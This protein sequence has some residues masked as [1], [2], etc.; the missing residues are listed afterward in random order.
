MRTVSAQW[1]LTLR[2]SHQRITSVDAYYDGVRQGEIPIVDGSITYD[3]FAPAARRCTLVVPLER[4]GVN[5]NPGNNITAPLAANG[6]RLY[7]ECGV[8]HADRKIEMVSQG[9]Y[10]I[11]DWS[12]DSDEGTV[13]VTGSDLWSLLERAPIMANQTSMRVPNLVANRINDC[14]RQLLYPRLFPD[15]QPGWLPVEGQI[16]EYTMD[17]AP[18][19]IIGPSGAF[20]L[21]EGD[22]R[23][24]AILDLATAWPCQ[25]RVLDDGILHV[26]DPPAVPTS[27]TPVDL[28][29]TDANG[30]NP[31]VV[32]RAFKADRDK[33]YNSIVLTSRN[34]T[35]GALIGTSALQ[36][37]TGPF[38]AQGPFGYHPLVQEVRL[39]TSQADLSAM[40]HARLDRSIVYA[41][42]ETVAIV[43]DPAIELDDVVLIES[44]TIDAFKGRV[45]GIS[46]PLVSSGPMVLTVSNSDAATAAASVR[47]LEAV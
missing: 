9:W 18:G 32:Q 6:Q 40:A 13:T 19:R 36:Y 47:A 33:I 39:A 23:T 34:A 45:V 25:L 2:Q 26:Q 29:L 35:T 16:L 43:P 24:S 37:V 5:Y 44:A 1:P 30:A 20:Q 3:A 17:T 28:E 38:R 46:F 10:V 7:I 27:T 31:I 41:M 22:S 4:D 12:V 15:P 8:I 14:L 11:T 21:K 42:T